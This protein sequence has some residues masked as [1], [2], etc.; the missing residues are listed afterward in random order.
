MRYWWVNQN[1]TF[2]LEVPGGFLWSPKTKSDGAKNY[3]YDTMTEVKPGDVVF[4]YAGTV[5]KAVGVA[6]G[7]AV[8]MLKPSEFAEVQNA[9]ETEGWMVPVQFTLLSNPVAPK[10]HMAI[11]A[12]LLPAKY[13]PLQANG[14]GLQGVYLTEVTGP[15]AQALLNLLEGQVEE[16]AAQINAEID[17]IAAADLEE[18]AIQ[19]N[20]DL[21]TLEK[22][23]LVKSR[24]GQGVF[25]TRV[26]QREHGC[27]VT[28]VTDIAHLRASHIKPWSKSSN[29]E[30][31]DGDNGLLL[32]PHVD[33]LF[34]Q[35]FI[36]FEQDGRLLI[37]TA[38]DRS[39]LSAWGIAT[40]RNVGKFSAAQGKYLAYHRQERFKG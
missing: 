14:N 29:Q 34:D 28:G 9:W 6:T 36:S 4:S 23:A 13:A 35:G 5:I 37:S 2:E 27:R 7:T 3:F 19:D 1:Q 20:N 24:R 16:I 17:E 38:L 15:L 12:P 26:Q 21:G 31:I 25:K 8:S 39:V 40:P 22:D 18:A 32:A 11:L 30:K 33:H 10:D